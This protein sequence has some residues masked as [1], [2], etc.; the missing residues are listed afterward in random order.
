M[1][2]SQT[3][4]IIRFHPNCHFTV[5]VMGQHPNFHLSIYSSPF[6]WDYILYIILYHDERLSVTFATYKT[7]E[8]KF[9]RI[10]LTILSSRS[11]N[12]ELQT[13]ISCVSVLSLRLCFSNKFVVVPLL[14]FILNLVEIKLGGYYWIPG[15]IFVWN[16]C[17]IRH[18]LSICWYI[19]YN[20][21]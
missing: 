10:A 20:I 5:L 6:A 8:P 11:W 9:Y 2:M 16:N 19:K 17:S 1:R 12:V 3:Q 13:F 14:I 15:L 18:S 21:L 4:G 7:Q